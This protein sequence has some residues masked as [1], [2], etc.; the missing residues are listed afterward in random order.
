MNTLPE[1]SV[2]IDDRFENIK[3]AADI[4]MYTILFKN[5]EQLSEDLYDLGI[6]LS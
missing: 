4:G 6:H 5:T 3:A 2:L 1:R